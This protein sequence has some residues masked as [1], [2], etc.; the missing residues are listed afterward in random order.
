MKIRWHQSFPKLQYL[1]IF[2]SF[3]VY[4]DY[5]ISNDGVE[6]KHG[7]NYSTDYLTDL[8]KREAVQFIKDYSSIPFFAY[9]STPA[10]HRPSTP[11]PQYATMF[12]DLVAPR[13]ASYGMVGVDKHWFIS[14]GE[15]SGGLGVHLMA[16]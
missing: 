9:I 12:S 6:E 5:S 1:H 16:G 14:E 11:A 10:P 2:L 7:S 3:S 8:V 15:D 4:Y 13:T